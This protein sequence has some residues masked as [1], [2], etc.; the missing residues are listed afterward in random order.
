MT[1]TTPVLEGDS[2]KA[3]EF[4]GKHVQI[5]AAAGSGKTE[6]VSQR[7][8]S[9]IAEGVAASTIVAFT[10]TERAAEELTN[11][12]TKR[13]IDRLGAAAVDQLSG[14]YV[15][16][17]HGYC[18]QLLQQVVPKYETYDVVD[19]GQH[20]ALLCREAT[21]LKLK[22]LSPKG[23]LFDAIE[24]FN[25]GVQVIENELLDIN[26]MPDP[27]KTI[28]IQYRD[29]LDR[30]RLMTFGMQIARAVEELQRPEVRKT[31]QGRV[32][33]LI[34]D[35]YQD[36][37]PAQEKLVATLVELGATVCVVGDDDQAIYQWRGSDVG[38]IVSFT[39][40]YPDTETF[41]LDVNRR[42]LQ[43][44]VDTADD[45]AK[46]IR[47]RLEK[48][49]THFRAPD[50]GHVEPQ[51]VA[52][53]AASEKDEA[54]Q[55]ADSIAQLHARGLP[56][57]EV[58][59]LVRGRAAYP[60]LMAALAEKQIPVQPGGR[61]GLFAQPEA[62]CLG[63][64]FC[65]LGGVDWTENYST[66]GAVDRKALLA[67]FKSVFGLA[68]AQQRALDSWLSDLEAKVPKTDRVADLVGEVYELLEIIGLR[69]WD[70]SDSL[71]LN[72]MGTI[73]RFTNLLADYESVRR[74]ARP[75]GEN[76][77][78]QVGGQDRGSWYYTN[79]GIYIVNYA[80]GEYDG[81][82]GEEDFGLD[83]VDLTTVHSAKG[84]EWPAV[85]VPSLTAK[86]F[87]S[88]KSGTTQEWLVPRNMFKATRYEGD[89][90]DER[91]LFYV[92]LTRAR[93]F[94]AITRHEKVTTQAVK[95]SPYWS[96]IAQHTIDFEKLRVPALKPRNLVEEDLIISYS[97][98]AAYMECGWAYRLRQ[99]LGFMPRLVAAIGYGKAVHH[100]MRVIA[101]GTMA[102]GALPT[103][104]E[105][106]HVIDCEFFLPTA[107]KVAHKELKEEAERLV[108]RYVTNHGE[109]LKRVWMTERPFKL[110]LEGVT[111]SGRADVILD[112]KPGS[113]GR[114]TIVDYKT[115]AAQEEKHGLQL[116]IYTD[117][118]R[119][120][121]LDVADALVHD[122]KTASRIPV[123][124]SVDAIKEAEVVVRRA[125]T[126][127][128]SRDFTANPEPKRC[129]A[130]D[131]K[132]ICPH[133]AAK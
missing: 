71:T 66:R 18:F 88:S 126:K 20:V 55:I 32:L 15:G 85:F 13:V 67:K 73:A 6:V 72:R 26:R 68:A 45:F 64:L 133:S 108:K 118:G 3:V 63:Q 14:M 90:A 103:L 10:F 124:T 112:G 27:F 59:I 46:T 8:A 114:L 7:V 129:T 106:Q 91:R 62:S 86:R 23:G 52:W 29:M 74:R 51:V 33:H 50:A 40:R 97:E 65:L 128:K 104:D 60:Q 120:E 78:E 132:T 102:T 54:E 115:A 58:A 42:S 1:A 38:N 28:L 76:P 111:V 44:I 105:V 37:N 122:M 83:A 121:G 57:S 47:R 69:D 61:S 70:L 2:K 43:S 75:D 81:F 93:D 89:D 16:T 48:K 77:G 79:L 25:K 31:M 123:D 96:D 113:E 30:Y 130:C 117:A 36:V 101:E 56:Y 22:D 127:L 11:R 99:R 84:L 119:R 100:V 5:I 12:I 98:L 19:E 116:Q 53:A 131:V 95:P 39:D 110:Y 9:L 94:V 21:R 35:E 41:T 87:P 109:E 24:R 82:E 80:V 34:V 125:A 4:R 107:N 49:M 92:A 17:I